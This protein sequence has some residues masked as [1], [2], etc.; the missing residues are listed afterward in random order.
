ME[1]KERPSFLSND[2]YQSL[3]ALLESPAYSVLEKIW[4]KEKEGIVMG[5]M[6]AIEPMDLYKSQGRL[7]QMNSF[8][9]NPQ[10][11]HKAWREREEKKAKE[12]K[13][14]KV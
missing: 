9:N 11:L 8:K 2:E 14:K 6:T 5:M 13:K 12:K 7:L 4:A 1:K 10:L 3:G